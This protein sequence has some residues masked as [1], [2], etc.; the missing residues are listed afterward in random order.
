[1]RNVQVVDQQQIDARQA[2]PLQTV[3]EAAHHPVIAVVEPMA[4]R[5]PAAPKTMLEMFRV[6]HG[7][8]Q[9]ADLGGQHVVAARPAIQ[10]AAEAVLALA[11]AVPRRRVVIPDALVPCRL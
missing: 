2:K 3:L 11:T 10:R 6:M 5:Q 9:P 1:M 7:A 8:E 4:E